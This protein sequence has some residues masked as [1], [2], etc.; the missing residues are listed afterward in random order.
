METAEGRRIRGIS[1]RRL[2]DN[3]KMNVKEKEQEDCGWIISVLDKE[4]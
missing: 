1:R 2:E 3:I 4:R